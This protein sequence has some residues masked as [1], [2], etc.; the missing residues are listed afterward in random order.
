MLLVE[1]TAVGLE[2]LAIVSA[3]ITVRAGS[4]RFSAEQ[5]LTKW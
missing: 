4:D 3:R 1:A 2:I 5:Q